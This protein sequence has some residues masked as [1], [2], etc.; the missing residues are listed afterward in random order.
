MSGAYVVLP[1]LSP[2]LQIDSLSTPPHLDR[3]PCPYRIVDDIGSAFALG[4]SVLCTDVHDHTFLLPH[5]AHLT[6]AI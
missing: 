5:P 3:E 4:T 2:F 1:S 6:L